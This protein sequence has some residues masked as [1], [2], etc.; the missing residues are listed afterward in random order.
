M[1]KKFTVIIVTGSMIL[2]C[3]V[4]SVIVEMTA[5]EETLSWPTYM[6]NSYHLAESD[7]TGEIDS[8]CVLWSLGGANHTTKIDPWTQLL[9]DID[10][11]GIDEVFTFSAGPD[12]RLRC[13][14][15]RNGTLQ[16]ESEY[17]VETGSL[18]I[19]D[20]EGDGTYE[21]I[22][23]RVDFQPYRRAIVALNAS[24]GKQKYYVGSLGG[25]YAAISPI[26]IDVDGDGWKELLNTAYNPSLYTFKQGKTLWKMDIIDAALLSVVQLDIR[27]ERYFASLIPGGYVI[28]ASLNSG[29]IR[30]FYG[31]DSTTRNLTSAEMVSYD[32]NNDGRFELLSVWCD[33]SD[34]S[35]KTFLR[36][37]VLDG[38]YTY[39]HFWEYQIPNAVPPQTYFDRI[40]GFKAIPLTAGD[41]EGDGRPEVIVLDLDGRMH[42]LD[43]YNGSVRAT[44]DLGMVASRAPSIV[45]INRDSV[46]DI[47]VGTKDG[48]VIA[49]DGHTFKVL[50]RFDAGSSIVTPV[51]VGDLDG[52]GLA[53][54]VFA[55]E[56]GDV[57]A[58]DGHPRPR[59]WLEQPA[60]N[61]NMTFYADLK[62]YN[63]TVR[64]WSGWDTSYLEDLVLELDPEG[65][66]VVLYWNRTSGLARLRSGGE[67]VTLEGFESATDG[68][69]WTLTFR[70]R[71][72]WN[73]PGDGAG[74]VNATARN[75]PL[76]PGIASFESVFRVET[77][78]RLV[79][80]LRVEGED[81]RL[82]DVL[83]WVRSGE[84]LRFT[85]PGVRYEDT[86]DI[87]PGINCT[88]DARDSTARRT[89][90]NVTG[91]QG[92]EM[93]VNATAT[94]DGIVEWTFHLI[95][96]P[97]GCDD[98]TDLS[99]R[100]RVD[101]T[102]P[103][104]SDWRP[105]DRNWLNRSSVECTIIIRD[106]GSGLEPASAQARLGP[107]GWMLA[108]VT[109]IGDGE[110][111]LGVILELVEGRENHLEWRCSD[112]VGNG[113]SSAGPL[114]LWL[115]T[116]SPAFG[117]LGPAGWARDAMVAVT[118]EVLDVG[119]SGVV[120]EGMEYRV[121]DTGTWTSD[122]IIPLTGTS[123]QVSLPLPEGATRLQWR[124]WDLA[125]NGPVES[126][127]YVVRVDRHPPA[128][129]SVSPSPASIFNV[130]MF[131]VTVILED[132]LSGTDASRV[133]LVPT[134]ATG[135][136]G[137]ASLVE[138]EPLDGGT[139]FLFRTDL[140]E[141]RWMVYLTASDI[142][143]NIADLEVGEWFVDLSPPVLGT[144]WPGD[145]EIVALS[146]VDCSLR[147]NDTVTWVV[148]V[149]WRAHLTGGHETGWTNATLVGDDDGRIASTGPIAFPMGDAGSIEWRA[150]DAAGHT[151]S[152]GWR[153]VR[154]NRS[155][156]AVIEAPEDGQTVRLGKD[157]LLVSASTD[158]D[159][160]ALTEAWSSSRD[161]PLGQGRELRPRL[162]EGE[163]MLTLNVTDGLGASNL[164]HVRIFVSRLEVGQP[165]LPW[166]GILIIVAAIVSVGYYL[167]R[168]RSARH[169]PG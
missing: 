122:G 42:V 28:I 110:W 107:G 118:A 14:D 152:S 82:L 49:I 58:L 43:G 51:V 160:Q 56:G 156:V 111:R 40:A 2:L 13:L 165:V 79:G 114:E 80:P 153:T 30:F 105:I 115:D 138:V 3:L 140:G 26:L 47:I 72:G 86:E 35:S 41:L 124:A 96:L 78:L 158:P 77:D 65:A 143:G 164:T 95:G 139:R 67:F 155:P 101:A 61:S 22:T 69:N 10:Q 23:V 7:L 38:E 168:E 18:I 133:V 127:S 117:A 166:W 54:L 161:G 36:C 116:Q 33:D 126:E 45:D 151:V 91:G 109:A 53:E 48:H 162:S 88:V 75:T 44:I 148:S 9:A 11:D 141:G 5:A 64:V 97:M 17:Q 15:G 70:L 52:D 16:W 68:V 59:I 157:V 169:R 55:T 50:W 147:V 6:Q 159:G 84:G 125:G 29:E 99:F 145:G 93:T 134:N 94:S 76:R 123:L 102:P 150:W 149:E 90:G 60:L 119:G 112:T 142:A 120:P 83:A 12:W 144:M 89:Y 63:V 25:I 85:S 57:I 100:L 108:S 1:E 129:V 34:G 20:I 24:D 104:L 62:A 137:M 71:F 131:D 73:W 128:M 130:T 132:T 19:D 39:W 27:G 98:R 103:T 32:A 46:K 8:P 74:R 106:D 163:H 87:A 135:H 167:V 81:T 146:P 121:G 113:P 37:L 31:Q 4:F 154:V 66:G 92:L 136:V 21:L